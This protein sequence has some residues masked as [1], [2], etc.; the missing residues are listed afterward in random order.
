MIRNDICCVDG[1]CSAQKA[2]LDHRVLKN[3][4]AYTDET[5]QDVTFSKGCPKWT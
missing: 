2:G 1:Q 4:D 5:I 3:N